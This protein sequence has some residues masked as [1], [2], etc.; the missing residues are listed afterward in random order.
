MRR[1]N[2]PACAPMTGR[3]TALVLAHPLKIVM[4]GIVLAVAGGVGGLLGVQLDADTDK[5]ISPSRPFMQAYEA[6]KKRFGDL[7]RIWVVVDVGQDHAH[8]QAVVD[9]LEPRLG[10]LG[11]PEVAGRLTVEEQLRLVSWSASPSELQDIASASPLLAT[12]H[13]GPDAF[14]TSIAQTLRGA[15]K[16]EGSD[17]AE[18]E[19]RVQS[20]VAALHMFAGTDL[21]LGDRYLQSPSRRLHFIGILPDKNHATLAV[22]EGPLRRIRSV[23]NEARAVFPAAHIGLTGKPV[24]QA[25]ELGT[26]QAD[27]RQ[28]AIVAMLVVTVLVIGLLGEVKRPLLVVVAFA[29]AVG[30][31]WGFVAIAFG[32][33]TLLSIVFL[34]IMI[35]VGLDFGVHIISRH[36]AARS[37]NDRDSAMKTVLAST[38]RSNWVAAMTSVVVFLAALATD[39]RGLQELGVIAAAGIL[40]CVVAMSTVLPAL[41]VL[42]DRHLS[43][44]TRV[45]RRPRHQRRPGLVLVLAALTGIGGWWMASHLRF[46]TNLLALQSPDMEAVFWEQ[47][48]A[49]DAGAPT[50]FAA[51]Q[52]KDLDSVAELSRRASQ[53]PHIGAVRSVLDLAAMPNPA[54]AAAR[55]AIASC[56]IQEDPPVQ[57]HAQ[58][59][60]VS[61]LRVVATAARHTAPQE[62]ATLDTLAL[63]L[64]SMS[65]AEMNEAARRTSAAWTAIGDG[66]RDSIRQALPE[67]LR[68]SMMAKDGTF[69][70][71]AH[72][73][74]DVWSEQAMAEFVEALRRVDPDV[75]GVP[76]THLESLRDMR[77]GFITMTALAVGL[78]LLV[79]LIEARTWREPLVCVI[80]LA[81]G[82]GWTLGVAELVGLNLNLANFF[83]VPILLGLGVDG[84]VHM[85]HRL[86]QGESDGSTRR[87]V[88]LTALTTMTGFGSLLLASHRGLISL[89]GL[90][91]IGCLACLLAALVVVPAALAPRS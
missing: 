24:I 31:T 26:T 39:F 80:A 33:L 16:P 18:S 6:F 41:L 29:L 52:A 79:L 19:E 86:R 82:A 76:I 72:P 43:V 14:L 9:W 42:F 11:L 63:T 60:T 35:G 2:V 78:V 85:A 91:A 34:L 89:G 68:A 69:L 53:E 44:S 22:I 38:A 58:S 71:M 1:G 12:A 74:N 70:L 75:T 3:L 7:E 87:A 62:A 67:A 90:M 37:S 55:T 61:A 20:A 56:P 27:M 32:R 88:L 50:W 64:E 77:S 25:D 10:E 21:P 59:S 13:S 54:R 66:A 23:L 30:W 8:A 5:L 49:S 45:A 36:A 84:A 73:A 83:A 46:E 48:I 4:A 51:M 28:A 47:R 81:I 65:S 15:M 17:A 57:A 40:M